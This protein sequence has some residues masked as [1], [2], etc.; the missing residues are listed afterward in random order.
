MIRSLVAAMALLT[1]LTI[2]PGPDLAVVTRVALSSGRPAATRT[3]AGVVTGLL[4]WGVLTAAGLAAVLAASARA[5][6][7]VRVAGAAF[8]VLLGLQT[9]WRSRHAPDAEEHASRPAGRPYRT[10]LLSNLLNPKIAVFYS[11]V[12]PQLVPRHAPVTATLLGLVL[13]HAVVTFGW[14]YGY[15]AVLHRARRV[16]RRPAFR[17]TLERVTGLALIGLGLRVAAEAR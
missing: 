16:L 13:A 4:V 5:Y 14:L 10:G 9:L 17:A 1:L 15:V 3:S 7:V 11:G 6:E 8:L 12:L 2:L